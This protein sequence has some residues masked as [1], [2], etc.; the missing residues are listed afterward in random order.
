MFAGNELIVGLWIVPVTLFIIVPLV[1]LLTWGL[2]QILKPLVTIKK[3]EKTEETM[4][5]TGRYLSPSE[6]S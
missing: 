4:V 3:V 1:I 6:S 2:A 5:E